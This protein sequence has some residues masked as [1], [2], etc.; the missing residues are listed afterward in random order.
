MNLINGVSVKSKFIWGF[1]EK[2]IIYDKCG[3]VLQLGLF[4]WMSSFFDLTLK[5]GGLYC[6]DNVGHN[7]HKPSFFSVIRSM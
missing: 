6:T 4:L 1:A 7:S 2:D 3:L 5:P